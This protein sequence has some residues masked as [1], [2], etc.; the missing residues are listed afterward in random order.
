MSIVPK[1][2]E[3]YDFVKVSKK[4]GNSRERIRLLAFAH[5]KEGKSVKESTIYVWL[6][7]FR[8]K[9]LEGLKEP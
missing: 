2:F 8:S 1:E 9:G 6:R 5:L 3:L 4:W 7:Y